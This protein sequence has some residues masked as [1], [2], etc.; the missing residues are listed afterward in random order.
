MT[1][2]SV[3]I[4]YDT[5]Y[6]NNRILKVRHFP[7]YALRTWVTGSLVVNAISLASHMLPDTY[8]VSV[9]GSGSLDVGFDDR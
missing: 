5:C 9:P 3:L 7:S 1:G 8:G 4:V 2:T 6:A